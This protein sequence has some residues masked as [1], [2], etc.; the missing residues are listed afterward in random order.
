MIPLRSHPIFLLLMPPN[1]NSQ[2]NSPLFPR[3]PSNADL[4][5][6][7]SYFINQ[8]LHYRYL[9]LS[10]PLFTHSVPKQV[11]GCCVCVCCILP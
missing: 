4:Q 5:S 10:S 3:L 6:L 9:S 7:K 11:E 2:L 1:T 8:L